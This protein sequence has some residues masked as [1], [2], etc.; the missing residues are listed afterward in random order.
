MKLV[1]IKIT[2]VDKDKQ[3]ILGKKIDNNHVFEIICRA[4]PD[5]VFISTAANGKQIY[6]T[7]IRNQYLIRRLMKSENSMAI[8][9]NEPMSISY[10]NSIFYFVKKRIENSEYKNFDISIGKVSKLKFFFEMLDVYNENGESYLINHY[11]EYLEKYGNN[12]KKTL[13]LNEFLI[14]KNLIQ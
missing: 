11:Q 13:T 6:K 1:Q 8:K 10:V 5:T 4:I 14:M 3:E 12:K 2:D 9:I 7:Y